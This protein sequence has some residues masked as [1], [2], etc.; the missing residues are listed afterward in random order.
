MG[1]L[2]QDVRY[3]IRTLIRAPGFSAIAILTLALGIGANAAIFTLVDALILKPLPFRDPSRLVIAWDTYLPQY[4]KIGVSPAE[5]EQWQKQ[6]DIFE[7]TAWFRSIPY[8]MNLTLPGSEPM[9]V[10]AAFTSPGL[11]SMLGVGPQLGSTA[12]LPDNVLLSEKLWKMRFSGDPRAIGQTIRMSGKPFRVVGVMPA[13]FKLPDFADVWLP[14]GPLMGDELTNP[15][16]HPAAFIGRLRAGVSEQQAAG[17]LDAISRRLAAEHPKTSTGWG[18]RVHNLQDDLTASVRPALLVLLGA[19]ALVLLIGCANVANLLLARAA[20]RAREIAIR[21][22]IGAGTWRIARQLLTESLVLAALGGAMGLAIARA[23]LLAFSPVETRLDIS[24]VLFLLAVSIGTGILFGLAPVAQALR[25]DLNPAIKSSGGGLRSALVIAEFA[26]ALMLVACAGI[27][28]KSFAVLVHV[29]PGFDPRGVVTAR[30]AFARDPGLLFRRIEEQVRTLPGVESVAG[31]TALP[32][33]T[34]HGNRNRFNVPGSP[35]INPDALPSSE[36][37]WVTPEYFRAMRIPVVSGRAFTDRDTDTSIVIVNETMARRFWP[38]RDPVGLKFVTGPWGPN[39]TWSTIVGVVGDVKQL[40][41]DAEPTFDMYFPTFQ[42]AGYVVV[43]TAGS[44]MALIPHLRGSIH[45]ADPDAPVTD[46]A[47]MEEV[48][49]ESTSSRRWTMTLLG[50]FAGL[51][52]LLALVGIYGVMS[53]T[54]AQRTKEIGI[55]VALGASGAQVL[56]SVFAYGMRLAGAGL[57]IGFVGALAARRLLASL[58]FGV[59][60]A[61]PWIYG[62]VMLLMMAVAAAA[63]FVPARRASRVDPLVALR[64]E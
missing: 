52:L 44:P 35:L 15:V 59:S 19:V 26:L 42:V 30:V 64:W 34:G 57:A 43:R 2:L 39:P 22:A 3:A 55:R 9:E 31:T 7:Q 58:V 40:G 16:R 21:S 45:I 4:P 37:R 11:F 18:I 24:A 38:G 41:L 53:W 48:Y 28:M 47:T 63:C 61:D 8:D 27:L 23:G 10:H 49:A 5:L 14:P 25:S 32:L 29:D 50:A 1:T 60:T 12:D 13:T 6:T 62:S 36:A 51:A 33:S 17:R 20:G 46:L 56:G 54:V